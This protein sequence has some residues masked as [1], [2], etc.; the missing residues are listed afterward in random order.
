MNITAADS[1]ASSFPEQQRPY[2]THL[3]LYP[4]ANETRTVSEVKEGVFTSYAEKSNGQRLVTHKLNSKDKIALA[5]SQDF[6]LR[7]ELWQRL[8]YK[9]GVHYS[10]QVRES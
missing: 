6:A 4:K 10:T 2:A 5:K 7:E 9:N 8:N 1:I 3:A